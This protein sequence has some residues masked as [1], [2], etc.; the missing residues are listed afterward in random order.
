VSWIVPPEWLGETA[1]I[2]GCGPSLAQSHTAALRGRRV[3]AIND[4]FLRAPWADVLYFCDGWKW[5]KNYEAQVQEHFTGRY[6]VTSTDEIPGVKHL[7]LTGE[8]GLEDDPGALRHGKN[9]GYQAINLAVHFG[10]NRIILLGYDM[11]A[12]GRCHWRTRPGREEK[13]VEVFHRLLQDRMLPNFASLVAP[14]REAGVEIVNCT[15]GSALTVWP[16]RTL[17]EVL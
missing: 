16:M 12:N 11:Q 13:Q 3:I 9:S 10:V 4:S 15:P 14:L 5:W 7:Q 17:E 1:F 2:L 6:I 8:Q